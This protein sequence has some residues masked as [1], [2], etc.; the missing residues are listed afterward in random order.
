MTTKLLLAVLLVSSAAAFDVAQAQQ[1]ASRDVDITAPDG[2]RLKAT[3]FQS[4]RPGP[5]VLLMHMCVTTRVSWDPV[6]TQLGAVGISALTI[7]N[8]GFGDNDGPRF[9]GAM[10]EVQ[11]QLTEQWQ[12]DFDAALAW[13]EAQPG[14]DKNRIGAGGG[15]C[16]VNNAVKLASRHLEV[17]SLV[18]LAGGTDAAGVQFLENNPWLPLFTAAAA[19]DQ[20]DNQFPHLMRWYAEFTGNPR[21]RFVGFADGRHGTEIFGP[22]PE[23]PRQI[24]AWFEETLI[25]S[26]ARAGTTITRKTTATS[27]FWTAVNE[28]GGSTK[29]RKI[30]RDAKKRD[31]KAFVFP[32][33]VVNLLA[34]TRLQSGDRDEAVALFELNVEAYPTSSNGRDSLADGYLA[35]GQ[36]ELALAAAEKCLELLPADQVND[37]RK[38]AIRLAAEQKI[39]ELRNRTAR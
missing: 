25:T 18:L 13:L 23:L 39:A 22:H 14:I 20:F 12:G 9:E 6:A 16:G 26:P 27:E 15:S 28:R 3:F 19:D 38:A 2:A 29:A 37:R 17:R 1:P 24:V 8:R 11:R 10:P 36:T 5:A 33:A 4:T 7:D 21:N 35:R 30:F 31:P 34:Y 32:E